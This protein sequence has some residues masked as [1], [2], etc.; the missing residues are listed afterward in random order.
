[1]EAATHSC[2]IHAALR[3]HLHPYMYMHAVPTA[4][5]NILQNDESNTVYPYDEQSGYR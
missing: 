5:S 3:F 1:M 2:A 4:H